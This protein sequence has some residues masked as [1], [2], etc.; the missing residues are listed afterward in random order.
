VD[1]DSVGPK[2]RGSGG[3]GSGSATLIWTMDIDPGTYHNSDPPQDPGL[4]I[5]LEV[6]IL[7]FSPYFEIPSSL[8]IS[9]VN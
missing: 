8:L 4:A 3:S 6:K 5:I 2:T 7:C 9:S 1:P